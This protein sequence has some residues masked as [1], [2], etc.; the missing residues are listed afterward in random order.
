[1]GNSSTEVSGSSVATAIAAGTVSLVL[2][3]SRY[4][5]DTK[6]LGRKQRIEIFF[7]KMQTEE[8]RRQ[9][10]KYVEP[11]IVVGEESFFGHKSGNVYQACLW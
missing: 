5:L 1:M 11:A 8:S 7:E 10:L 9:K 6:I 4:T 2:A 3:C